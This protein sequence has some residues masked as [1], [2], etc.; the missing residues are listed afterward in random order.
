MRY[1]SSSAYNF[2]AFERREYKTD[3][4]KPRAEIIKMQPKSRKAQRP[5]S[6]VSI[7]L[8]ARVKVVA[9]VSLVVGLSMLMIF[10]RAEVG[11]QQGELRRMQNE[12]SRLESEELRLQ[13]AFENMMNLQNLEI[14]AV[15]L[16]MQRANR[17]QRSYVRLN[18]PQTQTQTMQT[19]QAEN[20]SE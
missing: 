4:K 8:F 7:K 18:R 15:Q 19:N 10:M 9:A 1:N 17:S 11:Q 20:Y 14:E 2:E 6:A 12:V 13:M 3:Y 16:G 5:Q